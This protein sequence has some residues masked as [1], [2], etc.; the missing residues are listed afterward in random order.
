[1]LADRAVAVQPCSRQADLPCVVYSAC[2]SEHVLRCAERWSLN[3]SCDKRRAVTPCTGDRSVIASLLAS[4]VKVWHQLPC[5]KAAAAVTGRCLCSTSGNRVAL[6]VTRNSRTPCLSLRKTARR[7]TSTSSKVRRLSPLLSLLPGLFA[8][9]STHARCCSPAFIRSGVSLIHAHR[10]ELI[11]HP[12][13]ARHGA[14]ST[15]A[16]ALTSGATTQHIQPST[17]DPAHAS[18]TQHMHPTQLSSG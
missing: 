14:A 15:L 18:S 10:N 13:P 7:S 11:A 8:A 6:E 16:A 9:G 3:A 4:A 17:A 12:I 5:A 1:M 2:S